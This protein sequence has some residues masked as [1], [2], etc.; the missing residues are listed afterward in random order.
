MYKT[1]NKLLLIIIMP[2]ITYADP[3]WYITILNTTDKS[4]I[5]TSKNSDSYCWFGKE[6]TSKI[7][8]PSGQSKQIITEE[9]NMGTCKYSGIESIHKFQNFF[10]DG[11]YAS[12]GTKYYNLKNLNNSFKYFNVAPEVPVIKSNDVLENK[13]VILKI[14]YNGWM[15][16]EVTYVKW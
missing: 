11:G 13:N 6:L 4:I 8:I 5:I 1:R 2:I 12:I 14:N 15:D 9:N 10:I 7:I 3:R 16:Y